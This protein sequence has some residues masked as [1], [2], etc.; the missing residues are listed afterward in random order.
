MTETSPNPQ[1]LAI[2]NTDAS[3]LA[4]VISF[5]DTA[6]PA[7]WSTVVDRLTDD[8]EEPFGFRA[9]V[10]TARRMLD[11]ISALNLIERGRYALPQRDEWGPHGTERDRLPEVKYTD[12]EPDVHV[13][14]TVPAFPGT[15]DVHTDT[16][17]QLLT[18]GGSA[19]FAFTANI[20][21]GMDILPRD[22]LHLSVSRL[23]RTQPLTYTVCIGNHHDQ[24]TIETAA[25]F[26]ATSSCDQL[27]FLPVATDFLR[28][29]L[30]A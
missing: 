11:P 2:N 1:Y 6:T 27:V 10:G 4:H 9:E 13:L 29:A 8:D 5:D 20:A 15:L 19:Q 26:A 17:L 30:A 12:G 21:P 3:G 14:V 24:T 23:D 7:Q 18:L 28:D 16:I 25:K 22:C